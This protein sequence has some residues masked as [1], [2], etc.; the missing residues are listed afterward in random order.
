MN[1]RLEELREQKRILQTH[2]QW[3]EKEISTEA[4]REAPP[5]SPPEPPEEE[6]A[7]QVAARPNSPIATSAFTPGPSLPE[8]LQPP[9][10]IPAPPAAL[11][12][13]EVPLPASV[14]PEDFEVDHHAV[15]SEV[16]RG[17]LIYLTLLTVIVLLS[18]VILYLVYS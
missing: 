11:E 14:S 4:A 13:P 6:P 3:L 2:L 10:Q 15:K 9:V 16:R 17:C 12:D 5:E 8:T 7:G 18:G 1:D